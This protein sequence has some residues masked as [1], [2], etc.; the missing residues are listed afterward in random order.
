MTRV[1]VEDGLGR[2]EPAAGDL[3][4]GEPGRHFVPPAVRNGGE[5]GVVRDGG[6]RSDAVVRIGGE[7]QR[8]GPARTDDRVVVE[9]DRV[10]P[11]GR[12]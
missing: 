11:A 12:A 9:Q 1:Q 10:A 5:T 7:A 2:V 8:I 6:D 4:D 3:V